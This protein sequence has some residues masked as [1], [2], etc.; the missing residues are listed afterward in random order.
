MLGFIKININAGMMLNILVVNC[1]HNKYTKGGVSEKIK[2]VKSLGTRMDGPI[3][4][5]GSA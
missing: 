4:S 3:T 2:E 1:R 5:D